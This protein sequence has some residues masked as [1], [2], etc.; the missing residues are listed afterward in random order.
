LTSSLDLKSVEGQVEGSDA[1][2]VTSPAQSILGGGRTAPAAQEEHTTAERV[3]AADVG[4]GTI[5]NASGSSSSGFYFF[6]DTV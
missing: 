5:S 4:P 1:S 6:N 3:D 2:I